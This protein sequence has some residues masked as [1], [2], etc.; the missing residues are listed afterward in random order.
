MP[1]LSPDDLVRLVRGVFSP[2][3]HD[4]RLMV[5]VDLPDDRVPDNDAWSRR[6]EMAA[7]WV[8]DLA[9]R[10]ADAGLQGVDLVLYG[11]V[12]T[13]NGDLP[14][15]AVVHGAGPLPQHARDI[16]GDPVPFDT[17]Y[18][19]H[20]LVMAPTEF[21]T[22]A[23]LKNAARGRNL[24]AATMPGFSADMIPALQIDYDRVARRV[25]RLQGLLTA[26]EG[27]SIQ[28]QA[29]GTVFNLR[30]DLRHRQAHASSGR[31]PSPGVAGNLP[32]G[33]AYIVPYEGEV[34]GVPSRTEG[35]LP[36]QLDDE[37]VVYEIVENRACCVIGEGPRARAEARAIREEPAYANIAELGLG[38]L[39][40]FGLQPIGEL[41]LD[42]KLGLHIAFGRSDHF[43]GMVGP[44]QF[45]APGKVVHIDRVY[46]PALQPLVQVLEAHL[47]MPDGSQQPILRDGAYVVDF[48]A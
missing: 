46:V 29:Q 9:P 4:S 36:V 3:T 15:A 43:G 7:R 39:D 33:E 32:S 20:S 24:R 21:S 6:R 23:P 17:L 37:V 26:A 10:T 18:A 44:R 11:N 34:P 2:T 13:N 42:E 19:T 8:Q 31:F 5:L 30:L 12:G 28:L 45:T 48:D 38:V 35:R 40:A 47:C 14:A 41:L 25:E 1:D 27:C 22:T 16:V